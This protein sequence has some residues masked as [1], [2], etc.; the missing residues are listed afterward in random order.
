MFFLA[1]KMFGSFN[2]TEE[3]DTKGRP[4][5][6]YEALL[7]QFLNPKAWVVA[8]TVVTV[9]YPSEENLIEATLF[10]SLSAPLICFFSVTTWAGFGSS[11]RIFISNHKIK[12]FIE[13]LMALLLIFTA[14]FMLI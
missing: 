13:I 7:F 14:V 1:F 2:F 3:D 6:I 8:L 5:K 10:V 4:M 11:I 12:K 9:F